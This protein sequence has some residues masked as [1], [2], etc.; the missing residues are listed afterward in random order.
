MDYAPGF[1]NWRKDRFFLLTGGCMVLGLVAILANVSANW[2]LIPFVLVGMAYGG[3]WAIMAPAFMAAEF[4]AQNTMFAFCSCAFFM[5]SGCKGLS[6]LCGHFYD[7]HLLK[8]QRLGG[9][10]GAGDVARGISVDDM[11]VAELRELNHAAAGLDD[12]RLLDLT[13]NPRY[14]RDFF[15]FCQRP[16]M[17][18]IYQSP[19]VAGPA[20]V[21]HVASRD[22]SWCF[23]EASW[24]SVGLCVASLSWAS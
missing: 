5:A 18:G 19:S 9:F 10:F 22:T 6:V 14:D 16:E 20:G 21:L 15:Q 13:G 1:R 17:T 11:T 23:A 7:Q 24:A 3:N 8:F 2:A 12:A 4:G